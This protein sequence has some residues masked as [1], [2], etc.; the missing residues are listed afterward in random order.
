MIVLDTNVLSELMKQIPNRDPAVAAWVDALSEE[1]VFTTSVSIA[2]ILVGVELLDDGKRKKTL[3]AAFDRITATVFPRRILPFDD[4]AAY[5]YADLLVHRRKRGRS[6]KPLDLQILA[7]AKCHSMA[8]AT[9]N[10]SD[11]EGAGVEVFNPWPI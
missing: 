3:R 10:V 7:I 2:E 4:A 9:R 5:A 8:V 6:I 1:T 11:F